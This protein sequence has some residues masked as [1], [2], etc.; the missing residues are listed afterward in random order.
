MGW[1]VLA[2]FWWF[3]KYPQAELEEPDDEKYLGITVGRDWVI[4]D[5]WKEEEEAIGYVAAGK[6]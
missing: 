3:Q 5:E 6:D 2:K 4:E 1:D